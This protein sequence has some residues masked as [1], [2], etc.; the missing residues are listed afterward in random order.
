MLEEILLTDRQEVRAI[1]MSTLRFASTHAQHSLL[2]RR[3][4]NE[5]TILRFE[6]RAA[7][8]A[9]RHGT[10]ADREFMLLAD[11]YGF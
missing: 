4:R 11:T 8:S 9:R 1:I 5:V 7:R 3:I 6:R 10:N 2:A